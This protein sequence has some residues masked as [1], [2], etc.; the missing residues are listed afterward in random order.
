MIQP[1]LA[2]EPREQ[3]TANVGQL[4]RQVVDD[5]GL[6]VGDDRGE[7]VDVGLRER[8]TRF[9]AVDSELEVIAVTGQTEAR[10]GHAQAGS[11]GRPVRASAI[12]DARREG[13]YARDGLDLK[14]T[15]GLP[16]KL[17]SHWRTAS[18]TR[19]RLA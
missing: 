16:A 13:I 10:H 12:L 6:V 14:W 8:D 9:I 18:R 3:T 1:P 4:G 19:G 2:V 11:D 5:G 7:R 17:W 15:L